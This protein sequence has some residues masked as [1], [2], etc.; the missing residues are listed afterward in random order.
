MMPSMT[1]SPSDYPYP[2]MSSDY[3]YPPMSSGYPYPPMS[4]GNNPYAS[5]TWS[6]AYP[7]PTGGGGGMGPNGD[8][9]SCI[10]VSPSLAFRGHLLRCP[11]DLPSAIRRQH[12]NVA[13]FGHFD[14]HRH[15][16]ADQ[17]GLAIR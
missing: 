11:A 10:Q 8:L 1:A 16:G 17:G 3:P 4:S 12:D 15:S 7:M 6:S 5:M 9:Q 13:D 2:P 14:S